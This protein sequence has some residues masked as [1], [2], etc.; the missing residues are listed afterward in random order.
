M[1]FFD[2]QF[3][4]VPAG[5][6]IEITVT[7][8]SSSDWIAGEWSSGPKLATPDANGQLAYSGAITENLV[9]LTPTVTY[10][11]KQ[12]VGFDSGSQ[13]HVWVVTSFSSIQSSRQT[14]EGGKFER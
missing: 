11:E 9:P 3:D 2:I 1:R 8:Y 7:T 12:R 5:G 10:S 6:Q 14:W 4:N 13:K